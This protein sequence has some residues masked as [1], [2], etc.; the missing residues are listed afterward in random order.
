MTFSIVLRPARSSDAAAAAPL[1][2][3]SGPREL[4]YLFGKAPEFLRFAF[5]SG[6]GAFGHA[7]FTVAEREGRVVGVVAVASAQD[8][9]RRDVGLVWSLLRFCK[10]GAFGVVTRGL[11]LS[12]LMPPPSKETLFLSLL[13]VSEDVRGRSVGTRLI[14][15][16]VERAHAEGYAKVALDVAVTNDDARRLYERL[17][18]RVA[19][20]RAWAHRGNVPGQRRMELDLTVKAAAPLLERL[21][22]SGEA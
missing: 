17:G 11:R 21:A 7:C 1:V 16:V 19:R 5:E 13:G 22:R 18:F 20:Q 4:D 15:G 9:L 2:Y 6:R 10:L 12:R 3:C 14:R 8:T